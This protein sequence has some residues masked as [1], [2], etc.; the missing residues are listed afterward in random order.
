V[1]TPGHISHHLAYLDEAEGTLY[2]GDSMGIVLGDR[3]PSHCPTPPPAIDLRAWE[4]TLTEIEQIGPERFG[5]AHFGFHEN[6]G[7]R[8]RELQSALHALEERVRQALASGDDADA[9]RYEEEVRDGLG[10]QVGRARVD[11]YF[12]MF[13]AA[14]DWA[15]V[16][17]Y[18]KRNP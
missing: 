15:G 18:L 16:A 10:S 9:E 14:T 12:D 2:S 1:S 11:G 6:T 4:D 17:F 7:M 8:C 5:A 13:P 3:I